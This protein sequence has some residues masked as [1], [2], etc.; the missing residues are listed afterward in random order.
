MTPTAITGAGSPGRLG[1]LGGGTGDA[2]PHVDESEG[3]SGVLQTVSGL[4]GSTAASTRPEADAGMPSGTTD[5]APD[6][7][8]ADTE[9]PGAALPPPELAALLIA[10][11]GAPPRQTLPPTI[12]SEEPSWK[13]AEPPGTLARLAAPMD[14]ARSSGTAAWRETSWG[15]APVPPA[16][17]PAPDRGSIAAP[18]RALEPVP[19]DPA[20]PVNEL[21]PGVLPSTSAR[22]LVPQADPATAHE[23]PDKVLA[24]VVEPLTRRATQPESAEADR[25][26]E[27]LER[28]APAVAASVPA[29]GE[30]NTPGTL[31]PAGGV[32]DGANPRRGNP[33]RV[34]PGVDR[35]A[36]DAIPASTP[37]AHAVT[38]AEH[39]PNAKGESAP[40]EAFLSPSSRERDAALVEAAGQEASDVPAQSAHRGGEAQ[41]VAVAARPDVPSAS[42]DR[43]EA[44]HTS[45]TQDGVDR[46]THAVRTS[47][48]HGGMEVRLRLHPDSLGEVRIAVR[49]EGGLLSARLE[50]A[51]PAAR[52]A[53]E[54]G[55][56][57]LRASLQE[58]GIPLDRLSI[59]VRTDVQSQSQGRGSSSHAEPWPDQGA[60]LRRPERS[61]EAPTGRAAA[62]DG[63]LDIRI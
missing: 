12:V 51:T 29:S 18:E 39:P 54:S 10:W 19:T 56:E 26:P 23:S 6:A 55:S 11:V 43:V 63:R 24:S 57:A 14:G 53:L 32:A 1:L 49:W 27:L 20:M 21:A 36:G 9:E 30:S 42:R 37:N 17:Q 33:D 7:A 60:T 8:V 13:A 47:V 61:E 44:L 4:Q 52:D 22:P 3:F 5:E 62:A 48:A 34:P 15:V 59:A 25:S 2:M 40:P 45:L 38:W 46:V 35:P 16:D 50:T 58:Q 41:E 31:A 28:T